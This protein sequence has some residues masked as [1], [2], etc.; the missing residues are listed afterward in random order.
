MSPLQRRALSALLLAGAAAPLAR[1][2]MDPGD[3]FNLVLF[4]E[5]SSAKCLDGTQAGYYIRPGVGA[6]ARTWILELEGGGWCQ[7]EAACLSRASTDIGSSKQWPATGS[8]TMDGGSHGLFSNDCSD[9][10]F[11]CNASMVHLN[12]CDGASF[13]GHRDAPINVSGTP[14]YFRGRDILDATLSALLGT[15]GMNNATS[16][17]LKGCS[18]GGLATILHLDYVAD[19]LRAAVPGISVVGLPDAGYFLDHNNTI[20]NP[21]WTPMYQYV[22]QMQ[23]TTPSVD[24]TCVAAYPPEQVWRCFFAQYTAPFLSTPAFF[25][26]D[27]ADS[28]QMQNIFLLPCSPSA[29]KP[30][31]CNASEVALL[32]TYREDT[33]AALQPVLTS[34]IHGGFFTECVQHCHTNIQFCFSSALV[35]NQTEQ[36][37]FFAWYQKTVFGVAPPQGVLT[38]VVD[39]PYGT[40][41]TCTSSCSPY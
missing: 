17:I 31:N 15:E 6:G 34:P 40:N 11:F 3:G 22:V 35:Q 12:Y 20:G 16:V 19:T 8:P 4:P 39:G 26:Q 41:P 33:L 38:T 36:D 30:G 29:G 1:A 14:I 21:T 9:N 37:T 24:S 2:A 23:N 5:S 25:A 32:Q 28:W 27:L 18:A 13:A 10:E 7:D